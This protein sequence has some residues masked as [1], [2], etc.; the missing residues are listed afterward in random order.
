MPRMMQVTARKSMSR[1]RLFPARSVIRLMNLKPMPVMVI[2]PTMMPAAA[3]QEEII[4]ALRA[5]IFMAS[6]IAR[7]PMR[8]SLR[9]RERMKM[10]S[11]AMNADPITLRP[12]HS[13]RI[14]MRIGPR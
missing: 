6:R 2:T 7:G 13:A 9:N 5:E 12:I 3:Q 1:K 10:D 8:V 14:R 11:V 4:R